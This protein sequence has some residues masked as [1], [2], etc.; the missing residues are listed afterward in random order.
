LAATALAALL[1]TA[2]SAHASAGV[3]GGAS[4][5]A[6]WAVLALAAALIVVGGLAILRTMWGMRSPVSR[7]ATEGTETLW[8]VLPLVFGIVLVV[9]AARGIG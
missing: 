1:V 8:L 5:G 4:S 9:L 3:S 2:G 7:G 6:R